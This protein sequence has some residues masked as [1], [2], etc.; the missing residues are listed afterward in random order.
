[1][2]THA[3]LIDP[4]PERLVWMRQA[5]SALGGEWAVQTAADGAAAR[6]CLR[7]GRPDLVVA[8]LELPDGC[9]LGLGVDWSHWPAMACVEP[10]HEGE[11]AQAMRQG[12]SDYLVL[13]AARG[14]TLTFPEQVRAIL[15]K[16][17]M[18]RSL[19][20]SAQR[21][22][23]TL[24]A[25]DMGMWERDLRTGAGWMDD[26]WLAMLGYDDGEIASD[27]AT[28]Q[29]LTHPDDL[30]RVAH[31]RQLAINGDT[32]VFEVDFRMRHKQGHWVWINTRGRVVERGPDG[33][34]TRMMGT[35]TDV[36]QRKNAEL[37][38]ARQHRLLQAI[39][40]VQNEF[41]VQSGSR[42]AFEVLLEEV[43]AVTES[44]YAFVGEVVQAQEPGQP[45][46]LLIRAM[47][48]LSWDEASRERYAEVAAGGMV[49][50]SPD[51]LV[52]ACLRS[53]LPVISNN[54][55]GDPRSAGLPA[56]HRPM[57]AYLG[58]PIHVEGQLVGMVS[59]AN[60]P[61][62]YSDADVVFL[63]PFLSVIGQMFRAWRMDR[64]R[65]QA[66][67]ALQVTLDSMEQG[68]LRV[69]PDGRISTFNQRLLD[70][71]DLPKALLAARPDFHTVV[72]YQR[73]QG[74]F[75]SEF[76]RVDVEGRAYVSDMARPQADGDRLTPPETYWR[77]TARGTV[78]EVRSRRLDDGGMVRTFTDVTGYLTAQEQLRQS[79]SDYLEA[80]NRLQAVLD[81]IPDPVFELSAE[82]E[83]LYIYCSNPQLLVRPP[84]EL[85]GRHLSDHLDP[86]TAALQQAA[87]AEARREGVSIGHQYKLRLAGE[88]RWFEL[89]IMRKAQLPGESERYVMLAHDIT[90]RKLAE[91][92]IE[93]LA[94]HD[95][96]TGLPNRRLLLDRLGMALAA[97]VRAQQ[98]G[99]LLFIDL[100]N[101]KDLNDTLGHDR[102]DLLLQQVAQRLREQ[103]R[104]ADTVAR[105]GGDE[106][107][108]MLEGLNAQEAEAAVQAEAIARKLLTVLNLPYMLGDKTHN[109]TPSM[110][111][112]LFGHPQDTV[113]EL[114]KRADLAMYR[115]K[116]EGRNTLRFF[117][118]AMQAAVLERASL[119]ADLRLGLQRDELEL[120]FQPV[121]DDGG[122]TL[123]AEALV[124]WRHPQRGMVSPADFIP[125]AE[126]SGLIV[127]LGQWVLRRACETL[128]AWKGDPRL[129]D[130]SLAVNV[131]AREFRHPDFVQRVVDLLAQTGACAGR[132]KL[133]LT[134]SMFLQDTDDTIVRMNELRGHGVHF[135][136]DDFG[137]GYSSLSYLKRLPLDQLKIDQSFVRDV[138]EDPDDA[139]IVRAI[140]TLAHSLDL[141]VVAE[142]V[143][144]EGQRDFLA[145]NG[146][147][148]FQGYWFGRPGPDMATL[149]T[150]PG[151][152]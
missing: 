82:G 41:I 2:P 151:A 26:R 50:D 90:G 128:V 115:A 101:F 145:L 125:V 149:V 147:K 91:R 143:E 58:L 102:G 46:Q 112:A 57:H 49:F 38:F 8:V 74:E 141:A 88:E 113:D 17:E 78:L 123:G 87:L 12:F 73:E 81:A 24:D 89:S 103:V 77:R 137:T 108:V 42:Q 45:A 122:R 61:G 53:G 84:A 43:L 29:A 64:E 83:Y 36:S 138:L 5:L 28:R 11:A 19:E 116:I 131:S 66:R 136:L 114:L 3:L 6:E 75:G 68:I 20:A 142:G 76:E 21:L 51:S 48:D 148:A 18:Q 7:L 95:V 144:T 132:L 34:A 106:F 67:D 121:V 127:A 111:V 134:E 59:L 71:L 55:S 140:L 117:D 80:R 25:V 135:S 4:K 23:M 107:V 33:L 13:D 126:Q 32:D 110:G 152:R 79:Q 92:E 120:H 119:E 146:C 98:H 94:F 16:A 37:E 86:D 54:P 99:A 150:D 63:G 93:R 47:T 129:A 15:A 10:G 70:L 124:R 30:L 100:D 22:A 56:G 52:G 85:L 9:L 14:W 39:S 105:L 118:P 40:R 72:A 31:A 109:S 130:L 1:M 133:E 96:L 44:D 104:E 35:H 97:S 62:G 65:R 139:A 69:G 27:V 60:A